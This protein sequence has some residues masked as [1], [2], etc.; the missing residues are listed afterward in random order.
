[1]GLGLGFEL[2]AASKAG[3]LLLEPYLQFIFALVI[4]EMESH[5]LFAWAALKL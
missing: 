3:P 1:M 5:E 4:L 2:K